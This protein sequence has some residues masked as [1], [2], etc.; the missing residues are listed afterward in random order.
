MKT[1]TKLQA[2]S[3]EWTF[4]YLVDSFILIIHSIHP[5]ASRNR[6]WI[7]NWQLSESDKIV[8]YVFKLN[9]YIV[10]RKKIPKSY[11]PDFY[12]KANELITIR[13]RKNVNSLNMYCM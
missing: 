13:M 2:L 12:K 9:M 6:R 11:I 4:Q 3:F 7:I 5:H 8:N 10:F 1:Y